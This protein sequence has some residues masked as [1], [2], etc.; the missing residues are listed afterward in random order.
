MIFVAKTW[1]SEYVARYQA[2]TVHKML[3]SPAKSLCKKMHNVVA[4]K[5]FAA[6]KYNKPMLFG[7]TSCFNHY[8][9][10]IHP[11]KP[12]VF[13]MD[14][15]TKSNYFVTRITRG[16]WG[17]HFTKGFLWNDMAPWLCAIHLV[18]KIYMQ[19]K[20]MAMAAQKPPFVSILFQQAFMHKPNSLWLLQYWMTRE[21]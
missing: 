21:F 18:M 9:V 13:V 8:S 14:R 7:I 19:S 6:I 17:G 11:D 16:E 15:G 5:A 10:T 3:F 2:P 1:K 12:G 20:P 4:A